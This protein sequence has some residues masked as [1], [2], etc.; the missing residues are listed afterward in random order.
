M[1]ILDIEIFAIRVN[2]TLKFPSKLQI[3]FRISTD[4]LI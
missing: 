3:G 4:T 1:P 2:I